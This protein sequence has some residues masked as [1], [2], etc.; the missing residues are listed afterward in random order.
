MNKFHFT[1]KPHTLLRN[2]L[3]SAFFPLSAFAAGPTIPDA[4]SLLQQNQTVAPPMPASVEPTLHIEQIHTSSLPPGAPFLVQAIAITG[5]TVFDTP[6][7]HAL[8][9]SAEGQT[10]TLPELG[11]VAE[12]I[13]TYYRAHGYPLTRAIIPAQTIENGFV[14][15]AVIEAH[16]GQIILDNHSQINPSLLQTALSGLQP[17]QAVAQ[18]P[19]DQ[20]ML[21]LSDIPGINAGTSLKHGTAPG[22]SDLFVSVAPTT[23][24]TGNALLDNYG[25][26]YTG[27]VRLGSTLT[28]LN[29]L[30]HGDTLSANLLDS[31]PGMNYGSLTY[32]SLLTAQGTRLGASYSTLHYVLGQALADLDGHGSAQEQSVWMKQTFLRSKDVNIRGQL[33]YAYKQ[34][35]DDI[36][37]SGSHN[38]RHVSDWVISADGDLTD[39][40]FLSAFNSWSVSAT[41]GQVGFTDAAAQSADASSAQTQGRFVKLNA[42]YNRL[43]NLPG[44]NMLVLSF[45]SQWANAN[46]DSSE[47]MGAG[48]SSSVRAYDVGAL[49]GDGGALLSIDLRH[50]LG[51]SGSGHWQAT[52]FADSEYLAINKTAW[53]PGTNSATLSGVGAGL[54]W[55]GADRWHVKLLVATPTGTMPALLNKRD[56]VR[57]WAEVG[58]NF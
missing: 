32:E 5:N 58:L 21:L 17:G 39:N 49:T 9:A 27:R 3:W 48:G 13:A 10:L 53:A 25:S 7:L 42:N 15:I 8:I 55:S 38:N 36:D 23:S 57:G 29:P 35:S 14:T 26:S 33:T 24:Y 22:T 43:Q 56:N 16:I 12:R 50:D 6:T 18:E 31:G 44:N 40:L 28:M 4:G 2:L 34:L 52:V 51:A 41:T 46:L 20:A 11:D 47:K 1:A 54:N 45:S 30:N 19:I 37:S